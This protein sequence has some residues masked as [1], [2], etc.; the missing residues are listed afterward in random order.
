MPLTQPNNISVAFGNLDIT[1]RRIASTPEQSIESLDQTSGAL[2]YNTSWR[3]QSCGIF[4]DISMSCCT[5]CNT[6]HELDMNE[7]NDIIQIGINL[8]DDMESYDQQ[9]LNHQPELGVEPIPFSE[10][11]KKITFCRGSSRLLKDQSINKTCP[12]CLDSL[13]AGQIWHKT[14]CGHMYHS[15]CLRTMFCTHGNVRT[16]PVC[17][18]DVFGNN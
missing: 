18:Y 5:R 2:Q 7:I 15:K 14:P 8:I 10:Y 11:R 9:Q 12:I 17:R 4:N 6:V 1:V 13:K 16:C 3:C